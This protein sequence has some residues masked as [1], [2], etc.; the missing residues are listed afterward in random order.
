MNARGTC[1]LSVSNSRDSTKAF[2]IIELIVGTVIFLGIGVGA[3][4]LFTKTTR[5]ADQTQKNTKAN[6]TLAQFFERFRHE[7]ENTVQLPQADHTVLR[8]ERPASCAAGD[9]FPQEVGWGMIPFPGKDT[10]SMPTTLAAFNPKDQPVDDAA[11]GNDGIRMVYISY[12]TEIKYLAVDGSNVPY[13]TEGADPIK[14][15]GDGA[16]LEIGDFAVISDITRRDLIRITDKT[17]NA[18]ITSIEH[19]PAKS[20]WNIQFGYNYGTG[21]SAGMGKPVLFKVNVVT[22]ALDS[23]TGTL[24]KDSHLLD[25]GFNPV[26]KSFGTPGLS[27]SWEAVVPGIERFQVVFVKK[28]NGEETR[29]PQ[30]GIPGKEYNS[31]DVISDSTCGCE[32]Q[33]GYPGI[34]TVKILMNTKKADGTVVD[35]NANFNISQ[36]FN[37]S[38]LKKGLPLQDSPFDGCPVAGLLYSRL[39]DGTENPACDNQFCICTDPSDYPSLCATS[40]GGPGCPSSGSGNNDVDNDGVPNG[41]DNCLYVSNPSQQDSNGDGV[42]DA[43]PPTGGNG[44]G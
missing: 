14:I 37:P 15:E 44:S 24:M 10:Q 9:G 31:C 3:Y 27:L 13:P 26:S 12:D 33:L 25:D 28:T 19:S 1:N 21:Q 22:Y 20:V 29:T 6:R 35:P 38:T 11:Q 32:N 36:E 40:N 5:Q 23:A 41:N 39:D 16:G 43:C 17:T 2:T 18:G 30:M 7:L 8:L 34:K 4:Q 42:G